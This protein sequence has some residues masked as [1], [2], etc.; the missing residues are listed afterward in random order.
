M[1][2]SLR[3]TGI[4]P[5]VAATALPSF[6]QEPGGQAPAAAKKEQSLR[7]LSFAKTPVGK[8]PEG[9]SFARTGEGEIGTW[10]VEKDGEDFTLK[11][12]SADDTDSRF[13]IAVWDGETFGDLRL[14]ARF[15]AISGKVD[16]AGGLVFRYRDARNYLIC[17]ANAL[18]DNFRVYTVIDGKRKTLA[19][20][21]VEVAANEWH[22]LRVECRGGEVRCTFDGHEPLVVS[23]EG[24]E[25]GKVGLWTKADSV[26]AFKDV[27]VEP[28]GP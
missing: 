4:F 9:W 24:F 17:R 21:K 8:P 26:T 22:T 11:Q 16:Q 1:R 20:Q 7:S 27:A 13:P 15:K 10:I 23:V 28:L 19:S 14:T 5:L 18:E 6:A 2:T 12:V 25:K 3:I